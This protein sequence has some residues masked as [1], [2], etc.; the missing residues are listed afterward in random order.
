MAEGL[1][2][3]A[4]KAGPGATDAVEEALGH[5]ST[6]DI[7]RSLIDRNIL[8]GAEQAIGR[9]FQADPGLAADL[10]ESVAKVRDALGL[11]EAAAAGYGQV[12]DYRARALGPGAV[13]TLEARVGQAA[14]MQAA[15]QTEPALALL[16][17]AL[18]DA[19]ALPAGHPV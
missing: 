1:R 10:R 2:E 15:A 19:S 13:P 4:A 11:P 16:D 6:A 14:A 3:Q 12:A 7:A 18:A 17:Q 9:D 8:A 5:A